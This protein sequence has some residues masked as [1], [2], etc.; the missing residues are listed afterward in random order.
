MQNRYVIVAQQ[1]C[2]AEARAHFATLQSGAPLL[3]KREPTNKHDRNAI[4]V[5]SGE[6]MIGYLPRTQN[7]HLALAMDSASTPERK[8]TFFREGDKIRV[9]TD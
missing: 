6:F 8:A 2:T 4:G 9:L 3:L 5:W 7:G 1:F